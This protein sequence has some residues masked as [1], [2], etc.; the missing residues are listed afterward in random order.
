[1]NLDFMTHGKQL[2]TMIVVSVLPSL[3]VAYI[4][5]CQYQIVLEVKRL[6]KHEKDH[7][8]VTS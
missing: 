4:E 2:V 7:H 6:T 3:R 5:I 8:A 1:M